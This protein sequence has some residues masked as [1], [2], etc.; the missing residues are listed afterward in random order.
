MKSFVLLLVLVTCNV[1]AED[2]PT[3]LSDARAA[4]EANMKTPEG[5]AYDEKFGNEIVQRYLGGL[6]QCKQSAGSDVQSFWLL[7]KLAQDGAVREVLTAPA[8]KVASCDREVLLKAR[9]S[10]PPRG[11]YWQG[12][13][14]NSGR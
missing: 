4:I 13:Y 2:K 9:F 1:F 6:R 8:T 14:L 10:P 7:V 5:K 12:L 3:S 11:D